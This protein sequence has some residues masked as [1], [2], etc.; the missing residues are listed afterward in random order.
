MK[1]KIFKLK[2]YEVDCE[3]ICKSYNEL[4]DNINIFIDKDLYD[5]FTIGRLQNLFT[6]SD[7]SFFD[8]TI[9][10]FIDIE[11]SYETIKS[12]KK[13]Y[14]QNLKYHNC[15]TCP[16]IEYI[17]TFDFID[18]TDEKLEIYFP[19]HIEKSKKTLYKY[20]DRIIESEITKSFDKLGIGNDKLIEVETNSCITDEDYTNDWVDKTF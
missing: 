2:L 15:Y 20:R 9:E 19:Q 8:K 3:I 10:K 14:N 13:R 7:I 6:C 11:W 5:T 1:R 12:L 17:I 18:Y 16:F 4:V